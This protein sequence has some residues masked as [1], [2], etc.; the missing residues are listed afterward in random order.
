MSQNISR[1]FDGKAV[2]LFAALIYAMPRPDADI[3]RCRQDALEH[4]QDHRLNLIQR[5]VTGP[6]RE[7]S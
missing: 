5:Q 7:Q 6:K 1:T 2:D 4:M 3:E